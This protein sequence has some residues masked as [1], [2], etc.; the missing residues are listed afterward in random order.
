MKIDS[1]ET[2]NIR[3]ISGKLELADRTLLVGPN[4]IGKS[5]Y[6]TGLN[7]VML[8]KVPGYKPSESF[9]NSS[10]E[11][12][13]AKAII[14]DRTIERKLTQGKTLSESL[15]IDGNWAKG[16]GMNARI[17][18][19][20]GAGP[21]VLDM[22]AFFECTPAQ[23]R[24]MI[25]GMVCDREKLNDLMEKEEKARK[26]KNEMAEDRKTA[27]KAVDEITQQKAEMEK[28]TGNLKKLKEEL[29]EK[30][31]ELREVDTKISTGKAND[32]ARKS[33]ESSVVDIPKLKKKL[34]ANEKALVDA[35]KQHKEVTD[36]IT[37]HAGIKPTFEGEIGEVITGEPLEV[38]QGCVKD[39]ETV[40]DKEA[41]QETCHNVL[42]AVVSRLTSIQPDTAAEEAFNKTL[43]E[44]T[45][46]SSALAVAE[47]PIAE[48]VQT[49]LDESVELGSQL[50]AA[51]KS[52][53]NQKNI[54]AGLDPNDEATLKG[55]EERIDELMAKIGPLEK[56]KTLED[57]LEK[58]RLKANDAVKEEESAKEAL[59]LIEKEQNDIVEE[60]GE[61]LAKR[62]KEVL[63]VGNL[64]I[65]LQEKGISIFWAKSAD[66][67]VQRT[68]LSGSEQSMFDVSLGHAMAP[69]ACVLIEA[70]ELDDA[71]LIKFMQ[72]LNGCEYQVIVATC[73]APQA[74]DVPNGWD[75]QKLS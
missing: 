26:L 10:S 25:L 73:H 4:G 69:K 43:R 21:K 35:Q 56:I 14:G 7:W 59:A 16:K 42:V 44:W 61:M 62:S 33:V 6:L 34:Q 54:G 40:M 11:E 58:V 17:E 72:H 66:V 29:E 67:K 13:Y 68:S 37:A 55:I 22:P 63:P 31:K 36:K 64:R 45:D 3:G 47:K 8:G 18:D 53:G 24:R 38:V 5:S 32:E 12:M 30:R 70:A 28:P 50:E 39:I 74:A 52:K 57:S 46:E 23:K 20:F 27:D 9:A 65:E 19:A 15:A 41:L 75:M 71:N 51:N 49:L 48:A 2:R 1:I 60:A